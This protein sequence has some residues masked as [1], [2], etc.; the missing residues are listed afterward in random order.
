VLE[1]IIPIGNWDRDSGNILYLISE[2]PKEIGVL[3]AFDQKA[4][5]G[6]QAAN[7][8]AES[9]DKSNCRFVLTDENGPGNVRNA[10]LKE[11]NGEWISFWDSDDLPNFK[12]LLELTK[13]LDSLYLSNDILIG[14]F[15]KEVILE[16][17]SKK[18]FA[19]KKANLNYWAAYPGLWRHIFRW[20]LIK[21][22]SFSPFKWGEDTLFLFDCFNK[23][24]KVLF[25]TSDLYS[26]RVIHTNRYLSKDISNVKDLEKGLFVMKKEI[27]NSPKGISDF[28]LKLAD[29]VFL[30]VLVNNLRKN[31][32]IPLIQVR[33]YI[34]ARLSGIG[35]FGIVQV[36]KSLSILFFIRLIARH[37]K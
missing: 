10:A 21:N 5:K 14:R 20:E 15:T 37:E 6:F 23:S 32:R 1:G 35:I 34:V 3:F 17:E 27:T 7:Q 25:L 12:N 30:S 2:V 22:M 24:N 31:R 18:V 33:Q 13:D 28:S 16:D 26:Y 29:G 4:H 9:L 11:V 8:L 19:K 36:I